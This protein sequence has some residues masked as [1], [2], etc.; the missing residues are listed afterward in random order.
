V[1]AASSEMASAD[2]R[3]TVGSSEESV[4][5]GV[6]V[7]NINDSIG[8]GVFAT[9]SFKEGDVIFEEKPLVCCQFLWNAAYGYLACDFC[10]KPLETAEENARRL[11]GNNAL[12]LPYPE[13]CQTDKVGMVECPCCDASYC[14]ESCRESAWEQYHKTL[15]TRSFTRDPSHPLV[16]LQETWKQMHYPPETSCIMLIARML[17]T[18]RQAEDKEGAYGLFM[19]F[20]HRTVNEEEEIAHKLLGEQFTDQLETLRQ[21]MSNALYAPEVHQWL[22]PEGFRSLIALVGTNGQGVGTSA[23][24]VWVRNC[25]NL[26][27]PDCEQEKLDAVVNQLYEDLDKEAGCFLNNEGSALY[28]LQSSCNHSC[29]PNA[30]PGFP[31]DNSHLVMS[32]TQDIAVGQQIF[33]SYLDECALERSRHSRRKVLRTNYIFNCA[34]ER[35]LAEA[36]QEDVTSEE[37]M[38]DEEGSGEEGA[39]C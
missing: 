25:S 19:Q 6:H 37:E 12:T 2:S 27:L 4:T 39:G 29:K 14:G 15:C 7:R 17:S 24:S 22:T 30:M 13:C 35:C 11:T 36:D 21:L 28:P 10:M 23:I 16:I 5:T 26:D 32:A 18:V 31:Y 8:R 38:E 1:P 9:R 20:C 3:R 33:V 34:C